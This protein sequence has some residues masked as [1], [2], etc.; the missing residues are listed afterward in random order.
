MRTGQVTT[1]QMTTGQMTTGQVT[2]GHMTTGQMQPVIWQCKHGEIE[3]FSLAILFTCH[4][5]TGLI[6]SVPFIYRSVLV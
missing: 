4:V 5:I 2:T 3:N 6:F 1:G